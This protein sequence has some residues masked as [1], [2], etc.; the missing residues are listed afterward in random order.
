MRNDFKPSFNLHHT[1]R[2]EHHG[3]HHRFGGSALAM[4]DIL[5]GRIKA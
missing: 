2:V 3:G 4:V 1:A 5:L